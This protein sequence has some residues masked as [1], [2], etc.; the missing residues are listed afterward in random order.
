M[1][2][3]RADEQIP[4][5]VEE[6]AMGEHPRRPD[7]FDAYYLADFRS[8]TWFALRIGAS[9]VSEAEDL[10]QDAMRTVLCHW[11]TIEAPYAYARAAVSRQICR[12]RSRQARQRD[13]EARASA[14][15]I[16]RQRTPFDEDATTVLALLRELS[17]AQ[18][19]VFALATDGFDPVEIAE[20]TRQNAA[21]VRSNLRHS[22]R[23]L[24][25]LLNEASGKETDDGP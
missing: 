2:K 4:T 19:T 17:P 21:T 14:Q 8:L 7:T 11:T 16:D 12:V 9:C 20:I 13:A 6:K 24:I 10:A 22:R 25:R 5:D 15:Q 23:R 1:E 3:E 18:R